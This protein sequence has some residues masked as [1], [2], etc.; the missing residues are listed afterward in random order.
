MNKGNAARRRPTMH[1]VASQAGVSLKT[2][3]RVVNRE[4]GVRPDL[5]D[6]VE[7]AIDD[8]GYQRHD[9]AR[10]LRTGGGASKTIGFVQVDVANPFFSAIFRGIEDVATEH[11]YQVIAGS[12][13]GDSDQQD[14]VLRAL[15]ARRVDGIIIVPMGDRL[16]LLTAEMERNTSVV[17]LDL[18]PRAGIAGDLVRSDHRGGARTIT[19]HLVEHGHERIAF[20]GDDPSIFSAEERFQGFAEAMREGGLAVDPRWTVRESSDRSRARAAVTRLLESYPD[21]SAPTALVAGQNFITIGA[22]QA[23][24]DLD[25]HHKVALVGFD[26]VDLADVVEPGITVMPQSPRELG[27]RAAH[28]LLRRLGGH[29]GPPELEVPDDRMIIRGSGEIAPQ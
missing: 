7:T 11:G 21:D 1:D 8:L 15:I 17:F 13:D 3:S 23:L 16:G 29:N 18:E 4:G 5:V 10:Q 2:V 6:R 26:D 25:L 20:I 19:R 14:A 22:V 12:S 28:L 27:Q 24:H 9:S